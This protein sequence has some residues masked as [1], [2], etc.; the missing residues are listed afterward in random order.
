MSEIWIV[1]LLWY[2]GMIPLAYLI[3]MY[4]GVTKNSSKEAF[5]GDRYIHFIT[6]LF[7]PIGLLGVVCL[8]F[9]A[10]IVD[11][12]FTPTGPP[13]PLVEKFLEYQYDFF[14]SLLISY[15]R[16]KQKKK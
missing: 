11:G 2:V 10:F 14:H 7:W 9:I 12:P 8:L 6:P 1:I 15:E 16:K 3:S 5:Y 13:S 4:L